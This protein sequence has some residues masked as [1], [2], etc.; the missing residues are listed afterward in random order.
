M[1]ANLDVFWM[2][3]TSTRLGLGR[4]DRDLDASPELVDKARNLWIGRIQDSLQKAETAGAF[5]ADGQV[6]SR[7]GEAFGKE[8]VVEELQKIVTLKNQITTRL[9]IDGGPTDSGRCRTP[10]LGNS[11][12][13][14]CGNGF[15]RSFRR[16]A[17]RPSSIRRF[18]PDDRMS[19]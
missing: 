17:T 5:S 9:S 6:A 13:R 1:Q 8:R 4:F 15:S 18:F 11:L 3:V 19:G 14:D 10:G 2:N 7:L 12:R 16:N